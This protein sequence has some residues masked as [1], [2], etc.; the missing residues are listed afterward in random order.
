MISV[1][2]K[3]LHVQVSKSPILIP[4]MISALEYLT[5]MSQYGKCRMPS[6]TTLDNCMKL[7]SL[8]VQALR[9]FQSPF[10]QL[11]HIRE[12]HIRHF[13]TRKYQVTC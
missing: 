5:V 9:E 12:E 13:I 4:E 1:V 10:L 2:H 11:P 3:Y 8:T 7:S 6:L